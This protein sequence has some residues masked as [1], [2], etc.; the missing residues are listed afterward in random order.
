MRY[1]ALDI[2]PQ[3]MHTVSYIVMYA[4][5]QVWPGP[6]VFPDYMSSAAVGPWL[7][8]KIERFHQQVPWSGLWLDMNEAR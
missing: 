1:T 8:R 3:A 2:Q 4:L 6:A 5:S 7:Q